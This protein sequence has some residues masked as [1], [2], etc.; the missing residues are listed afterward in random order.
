MKCTKKVITLARTDPTLK[1]VSDQQLARNAQ[2]VIRALPGLQQAER[3]LFTPRAQPEAD[4][5][6]A[7]GNEWEKATWKFE[8]IKCSEEQGEEH[9]EE[10]GEQEP[11]EA[12]FWRDQLWVR[13]VDLETG[14]PEPPRAF[15]DLFATDP[16]WK[17]LTWFHEYFDGETGRGCGASHQTGWTA[18]IARCLEDWTG[19]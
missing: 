13:Q 12:P 4:G 1:S 15:H 7:D 10:E 11:R 19:A 17:G 6:T 16:H 8:G 2:R 14:K 18:L 5:E 9:C 3:M